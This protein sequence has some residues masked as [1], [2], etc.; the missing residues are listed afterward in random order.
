[1]AVGCAL[2]VTLASIPYVGYVVIFGVMLAGVGILVATRGAGFFV[3][4]NGNGGGVASYR[5]AATV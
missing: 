1:L 3:K 4:K 5:S 2:F